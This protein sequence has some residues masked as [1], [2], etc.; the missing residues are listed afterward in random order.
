MK[1][2]PLLRG[3]SIGKYSGGLGILAELTEQTGS[4]SCPGPFNA[5]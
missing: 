4:D 1:A 2:K 5:F 3:L